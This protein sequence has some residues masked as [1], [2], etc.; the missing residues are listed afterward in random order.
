MIIPGIV[1]NNSVS[2]RAK[3]ASFRTVPKMKP[4]GWDKVPSEKPR[5][6][7]LTGRSGRKTS[8]DRGS[9]RNSEKTAAPLPEQP[10]LTDIVQRLDSINATMNGKFEDV[11]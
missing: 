1:Q 5:Q 6:T 10:T 8:V 4:L 2:I 7:R 3:S 9:R 11:E